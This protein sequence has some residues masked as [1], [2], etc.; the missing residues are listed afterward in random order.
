MRYDNFAIKHKAFGFERGNCRNQL[1]SDPEG[2]I[3]DFDS[4][5]SRNPRF[6]PAYIYKAAVY[7]ELGRFEDSDNELRKVLEIDEAA[8]GAY[9]GLV[10][11]K[12]YTEKD[13]QKLHA[14]LEESDLDDKS[15][16][17]I[18]FS[19]GNIFNDRGEYEKA[20]QHLEQANKL[21]RSTYE[22]EHRSSEE[23]I[24]LLIRT[25]DKKRIAETRKNG[26]GFFTTK[27]RRHQEGVS[28]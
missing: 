10:S 6:L 27:A 9:L 26:K 13:L 18:H 16:V 19:L 21:H 11:G 20:F 25:F 2:A 1:L 28:S 7:R 12:T 8:L 17:Q 14:V 5:L 15:L 23:L 22:Y 3:A 24:S 4:V